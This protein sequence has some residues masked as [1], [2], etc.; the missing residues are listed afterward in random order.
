M[1]ERLE[2]F[3]NVIEMNYQGRRRLGCCVYLVFHESD[4][5]LIDIGY[6]DTTDEIIEMIRKLDFPLA[7]CKYLVATHADVDHI[8]GLKRAKELL[9]NSKIVGHPDTAEALSRGDRVITYAEIEAQGISIDLP[10]IEIDEQINE[11]DKLTLGSLEIEV[12]HTPG[13]TNGQ[14]AFRL[15]NL[16]FSGDNI[17]R[18]GC[19]GN[20]DAHH[21]SDIPDFIES[22]KRI[23][24]SNIEWLLPSHGPVFRKNDEQLQKTIERLTEYQHMADFG[25]CAVDWPLLEEWDKELLEGF[26]PDKA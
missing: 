24:S 20:I 2:L 22:L 26:D 25:T 13:H 3:P 11:G 7:N 8:Q 18:D 17:Y 6:E 9:P 16:L 4:W 12:W 14:L 21:G 1:I 5:M 23:K 19:V 10:K 15:E